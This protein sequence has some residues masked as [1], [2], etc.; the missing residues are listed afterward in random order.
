MCPS[1]FGPQGIPAVNIGD[2]RNFCAAVAPNQFPTSCAGYDPMSMDYSI[3]GTDV[4][5]TSDYSIGGGYGF[6]PGGVASAGGAYGYDP[7]MMYEQMDKW[8]DYMY[9]RNVRY[10]EKSRAND[11]RI[12]GPLLATQ[13]AADALNEKIVKDEQPQIVRAFNKFKAEM[14]KLYPQ[15]ANLDERSLN[16]KAME[17]YK[18]RYGVG[19][20]D[21]IR[22]QGNS[23]VMQG[24]A[25]GVTAGFGWKSSSE[26]TIEEITGTPMS[27]QDKILYAAG[28]GFGTATLAGAGII[29]ANQ[30]CKNIKWIGKGIANNKVLAIATAIGAVV[31][32]WNYFTQKA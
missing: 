2:V 16:A 19:L 31:G 22:N 14:V 10:T 11:M 5:L 7:N 32:L 26:E 13:Y 12:N 23:M 28:K 20:K 17:L 24:F 1:S 8:T 6:G 4:D 15:Y 30:A 29:A 18:Q 9:D 25:N 3:Y 27:R 21:D